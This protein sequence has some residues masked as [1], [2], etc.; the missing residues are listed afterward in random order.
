MSWCLSVLVFWCFG[1]FLFHVCF[2]CSMDVL[3]SLFYRLK[4]ILIVTS[5]FLSCNI[6]STL[7]SWMCSSVDWG[8][9]R[10][11]GKPKRDQRCGG[12]FE[13]IG[14]HCHCLARYGEE[15]EH[16]VGG[17]VFTCSDSFFLL[18]LFFTTTTTTTTVDARRGIVGM[19]GIK[20]VAKVIREHG[21]HGQ[22]KAH[23]EVV[24]CGL[25]LLTR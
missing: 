15:D 18:F 16:G 3:N 4:N 8:T 25:S 2:Q 11:C 5:L 24:K 17:F 12:M 13:R 21:H 10:L 20:A 7:D 1:V 22:D 23:V 19:G 9:G 6:V 14:L